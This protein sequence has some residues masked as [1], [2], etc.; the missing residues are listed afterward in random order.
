VSQ[1]FG[2]KTLRHQR[3][4]AEVSIYGKALRLLN[5]YCVRATMNMNLVFRSGKWL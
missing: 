3:N 1:H 5:Q 2:T 4:G